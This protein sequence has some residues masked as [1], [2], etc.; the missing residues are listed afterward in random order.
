MSHD[1]GVQSD[2]CVQ[3][4]LRDRWFLGALACVAARRDLVLDLILSDNMSDKGLYTFQLY[5][6]GCWHQVV[7][8]DHL[9]CVLGQ[10]EVLFACS[11]TAGAFLH[12]CDRERGFVSAQPDVANDVNGLLDHFVQQL[13]TQHAPK[14]TQL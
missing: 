8:D 1:H 5:K 7:V 11:G 4:A 6:H 2:G 13:L 12:F 10:D 3:G 9:P 14:S